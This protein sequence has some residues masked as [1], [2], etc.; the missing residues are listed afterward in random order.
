MLGEG[1]AV[2]G[3]ETMLRDIINIIQFECHSSSR[4]APNSDDIPL[5]L[6]LITSNR[7]TQS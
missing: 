5:T 6:T 7:F 4:L 1:A 3:D 2:A